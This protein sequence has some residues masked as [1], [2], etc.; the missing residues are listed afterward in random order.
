MHSDT[1]EQRP[2]AISNKYKMDGAVIQVQPGGFERAV[3]IWKRQVSNSGILKQIRARR[4]NPS[5]SSRRKVKDR[6]AML[7][8]QGTK[9]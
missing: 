6:R 1:T 9:A 8:R 3:M 2:W 4:D 7:R 5:V